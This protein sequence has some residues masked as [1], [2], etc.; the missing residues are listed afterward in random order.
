MRQFLSHFRGVAVAVVFAAT[1]F[2]FVLGGG[3]MV[4][5]ADKEAATKD[6]AASSSG[7][8]EGLS[9]SSDGDR[10]SAS[11]VDTFFVKAVRGESPAK[12]FTLKTLEGGEITLSGLRGRVVLLS[13]WATWCVPCK[14]EFPA[15]AR[16]SEEFSGRGL[17][18]VAIAADTKK[19]VGSFVEEYGSGEMVIVMDRYGSVMRDYGVSFFPMG[20]IVGADGRLIGT[21][22][23]A[24]D[25]SGEAAFAYFDDLLEK[26]LK[27]ERLR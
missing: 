22:T 9:P 11:E 12:D 27:E 20:V 8:G 3:D 15:L 1:V 5:A 21:M 6:F 23:G 16:L 2:A 25:Y 18:V 14:V 19:R 10:L 24:R 26:E 7:E 4:C 13:F 17:S